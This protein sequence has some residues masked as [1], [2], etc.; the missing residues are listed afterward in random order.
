MG[1]RSLTHVYDAHPQNGFDRPAIFNTPE[2][3]KPFFTFY[4]QMDGYPEGH[5]KDLAEFLDGF[6][7]VNGISERPPKLAN[8][9]NCLAAQIIAH[10]KDGAGEFYIY[11]A[12]ARDCG[13]EYVYHVYMKP[14]GINIRVSEPDGETLWHGT[15]DKFPAWLKEKDE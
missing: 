5:G 14:D 1:T 9:M 11:P 8:G 6:V 15:P 12:N 2:D 13:E 3:A 10:F 4:R 7:V